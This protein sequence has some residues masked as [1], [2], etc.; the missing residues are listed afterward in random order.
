V[1]ATCD[2]DGDEPVCVASVEP[3]LVGQL[4]G[5]KNYL[6]SFRGTLNPKGHFSYFHDVA[7]S[8]SGGL[9]FTIERYLNNHLTVGFSADYTHTEMED[10]ADVTFDS[11][12][13]GPGFRLL[14]PVLDGKVELYTRVEAGLNLMLIG[15]KSESY[16][17]SSRNIKEEDETDKGIGLGFKMLP[18]VLLSI[19]DQFVVFFELGY[20]V[21]MVFADDFDR[22]TENMFLMNFGFG[23]R[24]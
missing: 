1:G 2:S 20:G 17:S 3:T 16:D 23:Y 22:V 4:R 21:H 24:W 6:I 18:G 14:Y 15:Y 9:G 13:V 19:N 8:F 7:M 11:I 5:S 10:V 12:T